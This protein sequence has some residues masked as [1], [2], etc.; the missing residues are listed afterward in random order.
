MKKIL[1]LFVFLTFAFGIAA[2]TREVD[3]D[4]DAPQNLDITD[5]VLTWDAVPEAD[6]YVV[7]VNDAEY[8]VEETTF[9]LTTLDLAPDTYAVSVVAAKD[10][11]VSIPSAVLN[12]VVTDGTVDTVDAPTGVA[13]SAG[14]LTWNAVTDATGYIVY[15][16]SLSYSVTTTS[17]DLST[18]NIPVGTHNVYVV[19]KK[20]ALTSDNSAT[21]TYTVEQNVSQDNIITSV[22]G[23]INSNYEKDMTEDDF[24]DEWAYNEYLTTYDMVEAYAGAAISMG[25]SE[26]QAVMFFDDAM[27]MAMNMPM[28]TG[29][30]DFLFEL[31]ILDLYGMDHQDLAN[32]VYQF[33]L[34]M[35]ESG[36]RGQTL[37]IAYY[38]EE[39]PMYEQQ[40][41][42]IV[43]TQDYIDAYDYMKS[44]ATV[45]EYDG[46]D[47]F[48]SGN[49]REFRYSVEEIYYALVYGYNFYPE[50]YYFEDEMM[51]EYLTDMQIIMVAMYQDVQGQAFI[52]NMFSE[53]E[54]LFNLYDAIEWKHEAEMHVEELTQMNTMMGEMLTLM[55]TEETQFKGSLEVV[56]EFLLTVKDT[57]PQNSIDLIDGAISGDALTLTE[58]LIIKDEMVLMLQNALP[59]ATDFELLYETVL[60]ISGELTDADI[61]TGLQYAQVNGQISHASINLFLSLIGDI[62]ETLITGGQAI[63]DQA[64][65]EVYE[66][67]DFENNP[68][69]IIDF[70]LY[71]IDY[72]DQFK[73]DYATEIAALEALTTPAY[74]EYYYMLA[75]ENIIYQVE[76][77]AYMPENEKTIMLGMLEDLKL[78]F[79][80]YKALSDL[81]G[82]AANDVFRYVV[83]T[84]A[85][86]IKT[87]IALN[88]NQGTNM[89]Q[90]MV[91]LEQ[92]INDI[93]MIDLELFEGVTSA[94]FD[95]ILDA[96]RLPLKTALQMEG[97]VLPFDTMYE[98]LKPYIN[99]VMLNTIN[100]QADLMAQADLIDLDAFILNT[101]LSTPE[102]GIGLAIVEVLDNTFTAA[103][104]ALVLA[105]V[106]IVFDQIIEYTDI[107]A[108]TGATQAEVDQMQIDVKAQLNMI[109]DEVEA[110]ALLD[111]DNLTLADEERIYNFMMMFGSEQQEEPIIT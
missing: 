86:I 70:A 89:I 92:L 66:Y 39:I 59:A 98:A 35:L 17:I 8:E 88:E 32:I 1:L 75:I 87:V 28:M 23:V 45:D 21:V 14:V 96:A 77:D 56:F 62:D 69:V 81:L 44:F 33:A 106:D 13:I 64:Y 10:D 7:F 102:L 31:E 18:K 55:A 4:L 60:I 63:L 38:T 71:V 27:D 3:L 72:L 108:L 109:F 107:F 54:A 19:A 40:I 34:V 57:F 51:S 58:G 11:K 82:G 48:F 36:I 24:E 94:E 61:T 22:L 29:L 73:L 53:L 67:Y 83:D 90:M 68:L 95:I 80:T 50:D 25:M 104:E 46:L 42:D 43:L 78:E 79:D 15:V 101:N 65:D 52:N 6:H 93:N 12:Y 76:N 9:D 30:D 85:R 111:A 47:A 97:V 2:C 99:T 37:D 20:D 100:L 84:E 105:T 110:I 41:T 103:N 49:H 91:D 16:G 74:E 5:G 26:N